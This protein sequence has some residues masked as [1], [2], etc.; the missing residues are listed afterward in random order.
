MQHSKVVQ[1]IGMTL[2]LAAA[3]AAGKLIAMY[4]AEQFST[5]VYELKNQ[6]KMKFGFEGKV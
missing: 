2:T 6:P 1:T 5:T 4:L 3:N